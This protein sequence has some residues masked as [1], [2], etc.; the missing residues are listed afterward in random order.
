MQELECECNSDVLCH[1]KIENGSLHQCE[2]NEC[3]LQAGNKIQIEALLQSQM[4]YKL[5]EL[6]KVILVEYLPSPFAQNPSL[7]QSS[8]N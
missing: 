7:K 4:N 1:K 3:I 8:A 5:G 2:G 6:A